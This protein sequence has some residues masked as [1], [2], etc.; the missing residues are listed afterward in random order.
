MSDYMRPATLEEA[1]A[2]LPGRGAGILAGGTDLFA[3]TERRRLPGP[4]VDLGA[5]AEL[6]G[7]RA[8]AGGTVIGACTTWDEIARDDALPP[9]LGALRAAAREVGGWQVQT[10]G[11]IAGN[12]CNASPAADGVPPLLVLDAEVMLR[13]PE[14]ARRLPLAAFITGPRRT[15]RAAEEIVTGIFLPAAALGGRS[16]FLKLGARAHLVISIAMVA[17]R[18]EVA[19]RRIARAAVAVG[20]CSAVARRLPGIEAAL[21]GAA[22]AEAPGRVDLAAVARALDPIDD[23]RATAAYR[24]EAAGELIAR[25]VGRI[26]EEMA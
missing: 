12:I 20:A 21:C 23:I 9:A 18:L 13:G 16:A 19:E 3:A 10:R 17:V 8:V 5:I 15:I 26:A 6:R 24:A 25:A 11:T 22:L 1:L 7:V 14:G 4:V 2:L